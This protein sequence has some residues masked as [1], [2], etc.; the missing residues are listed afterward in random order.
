MGGFRVR[1]T[2]VMPQGITCSRPRIVRYPPHI[3]ERHRGYQRGISRWPVRVQ[4]RGHT[5]ARWNPL[6]HASWTS[7]PESTILHEGDADA[8]TRPSTDAATAAGTDAVHDAANDA[9]NG[10]A[11]AAGIRA[12]TDVLSCLQYDRNADAANAAISAVQWATAATN[13]YREHASLARAASGP[14]ATPR[15]DRR[16]DR[17]VRTS[18]GA[19]AETKR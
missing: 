6:P 14:C 19:T 3:H 10:A 13:M 18:S 8:W 1:G 9:Y 15:N 16:T 12:A 11:V 5:P 4:Q 2:T 7:H 17:T